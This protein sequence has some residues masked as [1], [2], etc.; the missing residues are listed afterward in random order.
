MSRKKKTHSKPSTHPARNIGEDRGSLALT[1][2][3]MLTALAA[4]TASAVVLVAEFLLWQFP[5]QKG[6]AQPFAFV[7]GLFL[8][9][10]TITGL[11]CLTL[12]PVVYRVRRDPPPRSIAMFAVVAGL[13]PLAIIAW[14]TLFNSPV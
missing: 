11:I 12:T 6:D 1:V 13:L 8:L 4:A 10:A 5:P 7:P 14:H 3:W 9:V 2:A